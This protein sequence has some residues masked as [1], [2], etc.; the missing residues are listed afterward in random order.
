MPHISNNT[1]HL[2]D[3]EV[4]IFGFGSLLSVSSLERTL[5]RR[6][7]KPSVTCT[8][9][10]WKRRWNITEPNQ[11]I[12]ATE[13][14]GRFFPDRILFLNIEE[15]YP[16]QVLNGLLLFMRKH[17]LLTLDRRE[18]VYNRIE[19]TDQIN[20]FTVR[21]GTIYTYVGMAEHVDE[22]INSPREAAV[23]QSY[24]DTIEQALQNHGP[25]FRKTYE[26]STEPVPEE[27]IIRDRLA[28]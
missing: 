15:S 21:R 20:E 13:A 7:Q 27:L 5:G 23:Q 17:D 12:Y 24:L 25:S 10:G 11:H 6:Y 16:G 18:S 14:T 1:I 3:G 8:I 28:R 4:G 9:T 2:D 19:I 26:A 22:M